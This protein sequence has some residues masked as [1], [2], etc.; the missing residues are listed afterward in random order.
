MILEVQDIHKRFGGIVALNGLSFHIVEGEVLGLIGPNGSGK[1]TVF[2]MITG[3]Y[4][5]DGGEVLFRGERITGEPIYRIARKGIS[6][7]F[8]ATRLFFN[9]TVWENIRTVCEAIAPRGQQDR[10]SEVLPQVGLE[11]KEH[12]FGHELTSAE[13]RLLM[14]GMGLSLSPSLL[15]LDEPT[16]GMNAEEVSQTL[17]IIRAIRRRNCAVLLIEHNMRAVASIC[18]RCIVLNYGERIAEGPVQEI[19]QNPLVI[20]A[21]LGEEQLHA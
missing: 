1:T 13:Q 8:Q 2:N 12:R 9:L 21:Y 18:D 14:I 19:R 5:P 3:L 17:D 16:A 10:I 11:G 15:L 7:T 20:K 4:R 6:R